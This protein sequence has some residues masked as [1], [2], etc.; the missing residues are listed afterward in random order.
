MKK[1]ITIITIILITYLTFQYYQSSD[2]VLDEVLPINKTTIEDKPISPLS[3]G[4]GTMIVAEE[5]SDRTNLMKEIAPLLEEDQAFIINMINHKNDMSKEEMKE[6]EEQIVKKMKKSPEPT[7]LDEPMEVQ[8]AATPIP[9]KVGTFNEIDFI[10]KGSG[11]AHIFAD[12]NGAPLLRLENFEVT[13]GP[14]LYVYLSKNTDI[15]DNGLGDFKSLGLLK[16]SKG[17]QNYTLPTDYNS[18]NSVVI[19]CKAFGVLFSYADLK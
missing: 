16:S 3:R 2:E 8:V 11:E 19:Y 9:I 1:I 15:K 10:H 13:R 6:A 17:N 14:D 12:I 7:P 4:E 18:Y 5:G